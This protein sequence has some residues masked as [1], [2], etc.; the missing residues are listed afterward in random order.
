MA[1]F[2][3]KTIFIEQP[4]QND[5]GRDEVLERNL[6]KITRHNSCLKLGS[7]LFKETSGRDWNFI[8]EQLFYAALLYEILEGELFSPFLKVLII[9]FTHLYFKEQVLR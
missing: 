9:F 5:Y 8:C 7:Q 1:N 2:R 4:L 6:R 3:E